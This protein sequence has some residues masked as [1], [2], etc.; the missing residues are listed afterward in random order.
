MSAILSSGVFCFGNIDYIPT[1]NISFIRS[2]TKTLDVLYYLTRHS[3][4]I[5]V[6]KDENT[7]KDVKKIHKF[8]KL[9]KL[10]LTKSQNE[11]KLNISPTNNITLFSLLDFEN[12]I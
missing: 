4:N 2:D 3:Q 6:K 1:R 8:S 7:K 11:S 5:G 9:C 12:K 10:N